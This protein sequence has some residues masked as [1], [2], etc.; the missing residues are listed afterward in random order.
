MMQRQKEQ[1]NIYVEVGQF[2]SN[3]DQNDQD[4]PEIG[5][6]QLG[7]LLNRVNSGKWPKINHNQE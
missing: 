1:N 7:G 2:G 6:P 3:D 4:A 5:T